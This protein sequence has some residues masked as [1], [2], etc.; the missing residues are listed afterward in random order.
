[1]DIEHVNQ[2]LAFRGTEFV[3]LAYRAVLGR[4]PD[5]QGQVHFLRRLDTL[6]DKVA[7]ICELAMS[8]EGRTRPQTLKGLADL[9][10]LHEPRRGRVRRWLQRVAQGMAATGRIEVA[11]GQ[12]GELTE[13]RLRAAEARLAGL[14]AD[15]ASQALALAAQAR[16]TQH[17]H[18][19]LAGMASEL[20]RCAQGLAAL[21][22]A[23]GAMQQALHVQLEA[24]FAAHAAP[25]AASEPKDPLPSALTLRLSAAN[26]AARFLDDLAQGL[27][28]S[29]EALRL[30]GRP[31]A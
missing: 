17:G 13:D 9:V 16:Q 3:Q 12:L 14:D 27:A 11:L 21:P 29:D 25:P 15:L 10:Q 22:E 30:S 2:L 31:A 8:S 20:T 4:E 7:I 28:A 6:H 19:Q 5:L 26:G 18:E 1:M 24:L 23:L